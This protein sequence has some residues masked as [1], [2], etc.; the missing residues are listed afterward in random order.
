[1]NDVLQLLG[2][3]YLLAVN[4][5]ALLAFGWDKHRAKV[6]KRRVPEKHLFLLAVLGGSIGA[7]AGV[8]LFHHKTR[9]ASF[10]YGLPAIL[11][12]QFLLAV[13]AVR[14]F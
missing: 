4:L 1:M 13:A 2:L 14:H 6:Q 12:V 8:Y 11:V 7:I 3:L 5:L 9:H 10:R